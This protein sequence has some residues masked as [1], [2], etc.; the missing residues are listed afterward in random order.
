MSDLFTLRLMLEYTFDIFGQL[1]FVENGLGLYNV[2][3]LAQ[4]ENWKGSWRKAS[5]AV[6]SRFLK[7]CPPGNSDGIRRVIGHSGRED[8]LKVNTN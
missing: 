6:R 7:G 4:K 3:A 5:A 2:H 1:I 8:G